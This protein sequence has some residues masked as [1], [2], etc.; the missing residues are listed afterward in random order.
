MVRPSDKKDKPIVLEM[1]A[2]SVT[3]GSRAFPSKIQNKSTD[4]YS[5]STCFLSSSEGLPKLNN[6][7][8]YL[9]RLSQ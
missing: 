1:M 2:T 5:V 7:P 9:T 3:M 4:V 6:L 8:F